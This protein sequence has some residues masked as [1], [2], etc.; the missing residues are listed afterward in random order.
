MLLP[1]TCAAQAYV[2]AERVVKHFG[3]STGRLGRKENVS[4]SAGVA[5]LRADASESGHAL[6]H[7]ADIAL[8]AAKRNGKNMVSANPSFCQPAVTPIPQPAA[9]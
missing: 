5:S 6:V 7:Q 8:Y 3:Q 4:L 2:I 9:V 1:G